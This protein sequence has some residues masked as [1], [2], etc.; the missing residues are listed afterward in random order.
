MKEIDRRPVIGGG[1]CACCGASLTLASMKVNGAWYC[2]TA[3]SS[4]HPATEARQF[5]VPEPR[6]YARPSRHFWR[7]RP[8]E[9]KSG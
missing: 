7:R 4:G 6:L 5:R 9:L 1:S 8:K 2:S 3:C